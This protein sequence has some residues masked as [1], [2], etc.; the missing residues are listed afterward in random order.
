[1][2]LD[3]NKIVYKLNSDKFK[4][5]HVLKSLQDK[6]YFLINDFSKIKDEEIIRLLQNK[7]NLIIGDETIVDV[8]RVVNIKRL[9]N[10]D[11]LFKNI[12]FSKECYLQCWFHKEYFALL[13]ELEISDKINED[14]VVTSDIPL[15]TGI[16]IK[17]FDNPEYLLKSLDGSLYLKKL[18][19]EKFYETISFNL[20]H[21]FNKLLDFHNFIRDN[22]I[23]SSL[24][25][26]E[27]LDKTSGFVCN[28][29]D[30]TNSQMLS[31]LNAAREGI[32]SCY[33]YSD[34]IVARM[35][36]FSKKLVGVYY[37]KKV[38]WID[39]V[40][41]RKLVKDL[42]IDTIVIDNLHLYNDLKEIKICVEYGFNFNRTKNLPLIDEGDSVV[43][44]YSRHDG[45]RLEVEKIDDP[46]LIPKQFI[47]FIHELKKY[48]NVNN[49]VVRLEKF[50][51]TI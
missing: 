17:F 26:F 8:D 36:S 15:N 38:G 47:L 14:S 32:V 3:L 44:L 16:K 18:T 35:D 45:W 21:E 31:Q 7:R 23:N 4:E 30:S 29:I 9:L 48:M 19:L 39:T 25:F 13:K 2:N 27:N 1:M 28:V 34:D 22:I 20:A 41:I 50:E 5:F 46:N 6:T 24:M 12:K 33:D 10:D 37:S 40:R 11:L 42:S 49:L 43:P 51:F